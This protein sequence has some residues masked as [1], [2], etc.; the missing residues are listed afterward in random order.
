MIKYMF[1]VTKFRKI[2]ANS[3]NFLAEVIDMINFL[4][5][6]NASKYFIHM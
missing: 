1:I 3:S 4:S 6:T 5:F 2:I